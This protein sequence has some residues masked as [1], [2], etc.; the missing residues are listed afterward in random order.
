[1]IMFPT[2]ESS[3][4][5]MRELT[6]KDSEAVFKHF[7][8]PCKDLKEAEEIINFHR[9]DSGCRYG[10]FSKEN[11]EL[12]GTC[13]FH[14]WVIDSEHS[15]AEIGFDLFPAYWGKGFMQETISAM[16]KIGF[17]VMKLDYV[18]ATAG[19]ENVKS[20][21]LLEKV[22]FVKKS[23]LK[24]GLIYYTFQRDKWSQSSF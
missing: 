16:L 14:C 22:G 11:N 3:R 5:R 4:L 2:I 18:E 23:C 6:L 7:S 12:V 1:M 24:E 15:C 10:L 21:R 17:D 8:D 20:Q 9:L 19:V 13:G